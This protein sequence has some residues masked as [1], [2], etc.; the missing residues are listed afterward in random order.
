M[1]DLEYQKTSKAYGNLLIIPGVII[2]DKVVSG[3]LSSHLSN[4]GSNI[5]TLLL[6][7]ITLIAIAFSVI[8]T[9]VVLVKIKSHN[10]KVKKE[11]KKNQPPE[12]VVVHPEKEKP[13]PGKD[14]DILRDQSSFGFIESEHKGK[15]YSNMDFSYLD[16]YEMNFENCDLRGANFTG[17]KLGNARFYGSDLTGASFQNADL[18]K[19]I[20]GS[21]ANLTSVCFD[22]ADLSNADLSG[23]NAPGASFRNAN[24]RGVSFRNA[25]LKNA[26]FSIRGLI[27]GNDFAYADL[28]GAKL[29]SMDMN[30]ARFEYANL[31]GA[32]L[33]STK[34]RNS[35]IYSA[36]LFE[37]DM[38][39][40]TFDHVDFSHADMRKVYAP[41]CK[42][43][44]VEWYCTK[45]EGANFDGADWGINSEVEEERFWRGVSGRTNYGI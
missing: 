8:R 18:H 5:L 37:A 34:F 17:A 29:S 25:V 14:I 33:S 2:F 7:F 22:G 32:N 28:E 24:I 13:Q 23:I 19:V 3:V 35:K 12:K 43:S 21:N 31:S 44:A 11:I 40:C 6:L 39:N 15:D 4:R 36:N 38:A 30:N 42:I 26:V 27:S 20:F 45:I 41:K 16:C 1:G 9:L 10:S